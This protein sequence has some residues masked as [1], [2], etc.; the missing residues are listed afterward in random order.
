MRAKR[1]TITKSVF[2]NKLITTKEL[3]TN[4][5]VRFYNKPSV[6]LFKVNDNKIISLK[7]FKSITNTYRPFNV[8][9]CFIVQLY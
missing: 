5:N 9:N 8:F 2:M 1:I 4:K 6:T 3:F 7:E